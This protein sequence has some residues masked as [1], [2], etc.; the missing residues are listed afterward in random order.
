M[1]K[2]LHNV[3][4]EGESANKKLKADSNLSKSCKK[5]L[6]DQVRKIKGEVKAAVQAHITAIMNGLVDP[7]QPTAEDLD[8]AVN[9][10][11][12]ME[13]EGTGSRSSRCDVT[14]RR[15]SLD[16]SRKQSGEGGI[17]SDAPAYDD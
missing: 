3:Q 11:K 2:A 5:Q 4:E 10:G 9:S 6:W 12:F 15:A 17:F 8:V 1:F 16:R 7:L 14:L 13:G